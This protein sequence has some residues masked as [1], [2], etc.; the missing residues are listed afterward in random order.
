MKI[1]LHWIES[2]LGSRMRKK[3]R[4]KR[5]GEKEGGREEWGCRK[6]RK[7]GE[8]GKEGWK[9]MQW[10][11]DCGLVRNASWLMKNGDELKEQLAFLLLLR[12][13]DLQRAHLLGPA[14]GTVSSRRRMCH[15]PSESRTFLH[16]H[17]H[18]SGSRKWALWK[19]GGQPEK[20]AFCVFVA[21]VNRCV[22]EKHLPLPLSSI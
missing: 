12:V 21:C 9:S 15:L 20:W 7:G 22:S 14:G 3:E 8:R 2:K 13:R 11:I 10:N 19:A 6:G 4:E 17:H 1:K 18:C 16:H 5:E